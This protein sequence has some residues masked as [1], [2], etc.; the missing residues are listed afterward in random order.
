MITN[1]QKAIIHIA[2]QD[3]GLSDDEYSAVLARA[4]VSSSKD[5][6][7]K[8]FLIVMSHL[9]KLGFKTTSKRRPWRKNKRIPGK[10]A[11]M[12]KLEAIVLDMGL[13][14]GYVDAIARKR[15][16]VDSVRFLGADDLYKVVQMMAVYQKRKE[17]KKGA[18]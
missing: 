9:E 10:D 8:G 5:L 16:G 4:G 18:V 7:N 12:S 2:K 1:G 3:I 17:K 13:S 6:D 14:W 11:L 15:F